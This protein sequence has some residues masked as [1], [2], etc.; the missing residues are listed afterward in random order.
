MTTKSQEKIIKILLLLTEIVKPKDE[1]PGKQSDAANMSELE[2]EK[3]AE[4]RRNQWGQ[5]LKVLTSNQM[6]SRL[7]IALAQWKAGNN[8]QKLINEIKQLLHSLYRSKKLNKTIY[9]HLINAI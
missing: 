1:Q 2:S 7:P 8:S 5:G 6:H 9:N 4:Q 3:S